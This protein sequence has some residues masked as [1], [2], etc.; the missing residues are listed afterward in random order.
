MIITPAFMDRLV[1]FAKKSK[2]QY[3]FLFTPE[4]FYIKWNVSSN[5]LEVNTWKKI[6][7]NM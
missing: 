1:T 7:E 4:C 2:Y 6:T 3:E 5:Y